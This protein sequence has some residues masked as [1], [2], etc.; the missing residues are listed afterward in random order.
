MKPACF[1]WE[2]PFLFLGPCEVD[3]SLVVDP[4]EIPDHEFNF[5]D[6]VMVKK[7]LVFAFI[8][9]LVTRELIS[10]GRVYYESFCSFLNAIIRQLLWNSI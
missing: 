6:Q 10:R 8:N 5:E 3:L 2:F 1:I 7:I 4:G 9:A